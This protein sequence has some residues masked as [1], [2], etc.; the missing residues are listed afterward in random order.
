MKKLIPATL[1]AACMLW[2]FSPP[3][4]AQVPE[5]APTDAAS[6]VTLKQMQQELNAYIE[7]AMTDLTT[8]K[9]G[10]VTR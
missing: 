5:P 1:A 7:S 9:A 2:L 10:A 8:R 3:S 6:L 4:G